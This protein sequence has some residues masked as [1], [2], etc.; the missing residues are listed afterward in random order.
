MSNNKKDD[1]TQ[2][3]PLSVFHGVFMDPPKNQGEAYKFWVDQFE[4]Y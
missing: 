4:K 2:M 1:F 3:F